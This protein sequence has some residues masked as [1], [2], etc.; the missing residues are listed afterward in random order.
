MVNEGV[1]SWVEVGHLVAAEVGADFDRIVS[2]TE[3]DLG[4]PRPARRPVYSALDS[5][6]LRRLGHPPLRH[7]RD[8][9]AATVARLRG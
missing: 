2:I 4:L 7:H 1:A 8:A 6:A 9:V 5:A 3:S